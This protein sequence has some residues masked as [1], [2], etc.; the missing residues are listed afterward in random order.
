MKNIALIFFLFISSVAN[1]QIINPENLLNNFNIC[2]TK[3]SLGQRCKLIDFDYIKF[4]KSGKKTIDKNTILYEVD[5]WDYYFEIVDST[6]EKAVIRFTDKAKFSKYHTV[7]LITLKYKSAYSKWDLASNETVYPKS[8]ARYTVPNTEIMSHL[9]PETINQLNYFRNLK[10]QKIELDCTIDKYRD[11]YF[12][13]KTRYFSSFRDKVFLDFN[14]NQATLEWIGFGL[15]RDLA[16]SNNKFYKKD[17]PF[18]F[19]KIIYESEKD[20]KKALNYTPRFQ[21]I[22]VV[23]NQVHLFEISYSDEIGTLQYSIYQLGEDSFKNFIKFH[24]KTGQV[25]EFKKWK[26]NYEIEISKKSS[27]NHLLTEINY[28]YWSLGSCS[29]KEIKSKY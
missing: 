20:K 28:K 4:L 3:S 19:E 12:E 11:D 13:I 7:S 16:K 15:T 2:E 22:M 17:I 24:Y 14:L 8:E 21:A 10:I 23:P 25:S 27:R 9:F 5:D 1:A 26:E 29:G 18:Y 6:N